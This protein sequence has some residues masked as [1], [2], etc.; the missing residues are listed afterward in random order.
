MH[1]SEDAVDRIVARGNPAR[2]EHQQEAEQQPLQATGNHIEYYRTEERIRIH[3][4]AALEQE[5]ST[6]R[7]DNIDYLIRDRLVKAEGS[8]ISERVEVTIPPRAADATSSP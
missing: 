6:V 2:L 8:N 1:N 7:S 4:K 3:E 5:G